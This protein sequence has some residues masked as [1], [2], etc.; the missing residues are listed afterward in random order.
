MGGG[1]AR[2][3]HPILGALAGGGALSRRTRSAYGHAMSTT[4]W[5]NDPDL[6]G[7]FHPRHP[8]HL[9]VIVHDGEPRRTKRGPEGCWV[10]VE[11]VH[12]TL[13]FP[14]MTRDAQ[15]PIDARSAQWLERPVYRGTLLN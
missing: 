6:A 4:P 2:P 8:D 3:A 15:P 7:R 14:N 13:R 1:N 10:N 11:A 5:R 12:A 9:Q